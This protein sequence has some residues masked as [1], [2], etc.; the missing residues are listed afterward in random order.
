MIIRRFSRRYCKIKLTALHIQQITKSL[1]RNDQ[2]RKSSVG[3]LFSQAVYIHC[4][5][6]V[7]YIAVG[8]PQH[9]HELFAADDLAL[10]M[11]K[12]RQNTILVFSQIDIFSLIDKRAVC[13][14]EIRDHPISCVNLQ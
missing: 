11:E 1:F 12:N 6:I 5:S 14:I 10:V 2:F 3:Q 8:L 7:I 13:R 9:I 4:Q